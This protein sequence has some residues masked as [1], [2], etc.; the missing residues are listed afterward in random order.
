MRTSFHACLAFLAG[1]IPV[2]FAATTFETDPV[3]LQQATLAALRQD[4]AARAQIYLE[5]WRQQ[6]PRNLTYLQLQAHAY[7]Q[8]D[9]PAAAVETATLALALPQLDAD[10][11]RNLL[12]MRAES[13]MRCGEF[14]AAHRQFTHILE[15]Y[16]L[17]ADLRQ[18]VTENRLAAMKAHYD[19][20]VSP[21]QPPELDLALDPADVPP[22]LAFLMVVSAYPPTRKINPHPDLVDWAVRAAKAY[23]E[24]PELVHIALYLSLRFY[25]RDEASLLELPG[26]Q[27]LPEVLRQRLEQARKSRGSYGNYYPPPDT[28]DPVPLDTDPTAESAPDFL[29]DVIQK[30][31]ETQDKTDELVQERDALHAAAL[32]L[33]TQ[34]EQLKPGPGVGPLLNET[35]ATYLAL[36]ERHTAWLTA[37][38]PLIDDMEAFLVDRGLHIIRTKKL[39]PEAEL[40]PVLEARHARIHILKRDYDK[41]PDNALRKARDRWLAAYHRL[42][43]AA[44]LEEALASESWQAALNASQLYL[45]SGY[46]PNAWIYEGRRDAAEAL[47]DYDTAFHAALQLMDLEPV[48]AD[49]QLAWLEQQQARARGLLPQAATAI[50]ERRI[51]E[52]SDLLREISLYLPN[53]PEV[54]AQRYRLAEQ[55]GEPQAKVDVLRDFYYLY[56]PLPVSTS[57]ALNLALAAQDWAFLLFLSESGAGYDDEQTL[58]HYIAARA[59]NLEG[60]VNR[61]WPLVQGSGHVTVGSPIEGRFSRLK[62]LAPQELK[63]DYRNRLQ[64]LMTDPTTPLD[65]RISTASRLHRDGPPAPVMPIRAT[66]P[67][68]LPYGAKAEVEHMEA[69]LPGQR[70]FLGGKTEISGVPQGLRALRV[71]GGSADALTSVLIR[72]DGETFTQDEVPSLRLVEARNASIRFV[73]RITMGEDSALTVYR[74]GVNDI[75]TFGGHGLVQSSVL[76]LWNTTDTAEL[77]MDHVSL[78]MD[79]SRAQGTLAGSVTARNGLMMMTGAKVTVPAAGRFSLDNMAVVWSSAASK[80]DRLLEIAEGADVQLRG[81]QFIGLGSGQVSLPAGTELPG[82]TTVGDETPLLIGGQPA[83]APQHRHL[84]KQY[85]GATYEANTVEELFAAAAKATRGDTILLKP[86]TNYELPYALNLPDGVHLRTQQR[87]MF[88]TLSITADAKTPGT[89]MVVEDGVV[90]IDD[91]RFRIHKYRMPNGNP[92]SSAGDARQVGLVIANSVAVM[93][94][95]EIYAY[96]F[97]APWSGLSVQH[98]SLLVADKMMLHGN[99]YIYHQG[100]AILSDVTVRSEAKLGDAGT[101]RMLMSDKADRSIEVD[102]P[103]LKVLGAVHGLDFS[104][105]AGDPLAKQRYQLALANRNRLWKEAERKLASEWNGVANADGRETAVKRFY[106]RLLRADFSDDLN[107]REAGTHAAQVLN[108]YFRQRLSEAGRHY[109]A[110]RISP[111]ILMNNAFEKDILKAIFAYTSGA[112]SVGYDATQEE[113][114][115]AAAFFRRYSPGS[116]YY[117]LAYRLLNEGK[118]FATI[119]NAVETRQAEDAAA[120]RAAIA[121]AE[122]RKERRE[123]QRQQWEEYNRRRAEQRAARTATWQEAYSAYRASRPPLISSGQLQRA[124]QNQVRTM[125]R[126]NLQMYKSGNRPMYNVPGW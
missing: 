5:Q 50:Q 82:C 6:E 102:D 108:P 30:L 14:L 94:N 114:D 25:H 70:I 59:L 106:G 112:R 11:R 101:L 42:T 16:D 91:V 39:V 4:D 23:P 79:L 90:R 1:I 47:G 40:T 77:V 109:F 52:A 65:E 9:A 80:G 81:S 54:L 67:M 87:L 56:E 76:Q 13:M 49:Q 27:K 37:R 33:Q 68:H 125:Q 72:N 34:L 57:E 89:I 35:E 44:R 93:R 55:I 104:N 2:A 53:D 62:S 117:H 97:L 84:P 58:Y 3:K 86:W 113:I 46:E 26:Y 124:R 19:L 96:D 45:A 60:I 18:R 119:K 48:A 88:A 63:E 121:A 38:T 122:R 69:L 103:H 107:H 120:R 110:A 29:A 22:D 66:D 43:F 85:E 32:T 36:A 74:G 100:E 51:G 8:L 41:M 123:Q 99:G 71:H 21:S 10:T 126:Q 28:D 20:T 15:Q 95:V 78:D 31:K 116:P 7:N 24:K 92:A 64:A 17:D 73:G 61:T 12:L 115:R 98:G 111:V 75:L 118:D 105:G 83:Q